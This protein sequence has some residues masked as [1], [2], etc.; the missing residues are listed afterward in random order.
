[1]LRHAELVLNLMRCIAPSAAAEDEKEELN[2]HSPAML[3]KTR[4]VS[5]AVEDVNGEELLKPAAEAVAPSK[6]LETEDDELEWPVD[7]EVFG[8]ADIA[9]MAA[10]LLRMILELCG[11][12]C[13][14]ADTPICLLRY[15]VQ[16]NA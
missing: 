3:K 4:P 7:A 10:L 13:S 5:S 2:Q 16:H 8:A 9:E 11:E 14:L 1:M 15:V 12:R 6:K